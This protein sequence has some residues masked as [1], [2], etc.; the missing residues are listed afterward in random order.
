MRAE[1]TFP[2]LV[3]PKTYLECFDLFSEVLIGL[4]GVL[5]AVERDV[6]GVVDRRLAG[7]NLGTVRT[8][9]QLLKANNSVRIMI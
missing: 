5:R 8:V 4:L 1:G 2:F 3:A 6:P 7:H 9:K